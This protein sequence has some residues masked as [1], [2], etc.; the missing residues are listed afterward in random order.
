MKKEIYPKLTLIGAGPGNPE[1]ITVKGANA[2]GEADVVL[3][4]A[5]VNKEI[6]KYAPIDSLKIFVE[7]EN[8]NIHKNKLTRLL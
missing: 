5:L 6:L 3:Y 1:L 8:T 2:L 4:D 7:A